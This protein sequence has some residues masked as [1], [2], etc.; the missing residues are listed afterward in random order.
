[1][2]GPNG[3]GKSTLISLLSG[4]FAARHGRILIAGYDM[5]VEPR[6]ALGSMG[7]VFQNS[8]LDV[9]LTVLQNMLYYAALHGLS[10][11]PARAASEAAL[12]RLGMRER[13]GEKVKTLN[14]GH[15]RRMEIARALIH[16]PSVLLLDEP[17]AGL[18]MTMR[19]SIT[20][21]V[22]QLAEEG[23]MSVLWTTHLADEIDPKDDVLI[24]HRGKLAAQG[25]CEA[26]T[27]SVT[28]SE[29]FQRLTSEAEAA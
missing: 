7:I 10:G 29:L 22:H 15:R 14:G 5:A 6:K 21:Y 16:S 9:D 23:G 28:L 17:T 27:G 20:A 25:T 4:L 12:D 26:L 3:A 2:L 11:K 19:K 18:D 1:M 24:L 13:M 8:T